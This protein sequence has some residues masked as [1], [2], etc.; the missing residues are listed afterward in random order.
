MKS[1][2]APKSNTPPARR[3]PFEFT[4][5]RDEEPETHVFQARAVTDMAGLSNLLTSA[6][7]DPE[8]ALPGILAM[9]AKLLDNKDGT[10]AKWEAKMVTPPRLDRV[11]IMTDDDPERMLPVAEYVEQLDD[12]Q[13]RKFRG[14]DGALHPF[15]EADRFLVFEAG[16]SRRRWLYLMNE[17]DELNVEAQPIIELFE[18][19]AG[20]A[21]N[22]PTRPSS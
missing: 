3:E 12:A 20:L 6:R 7:R 8:Q 18:W 5:M 1:F 11:D 15:E 13:V 10:P 22:R 4:F 2:G 16:S 21:A 9:I 14:P 19:M 17:D